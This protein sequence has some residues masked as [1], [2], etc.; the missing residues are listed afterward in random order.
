MAFQR[1]GTRITR[2]VD[3]APA[4]GLASNTIVV[5]TATGVAKSG[6]KAVPFFGVTQGASDAKGYADIQTDNVVQILAG[7]TIAAGASVASDANG[8]AVSVTPAGTGS[9]T[10]VVGTAI[11]AAVSGGLVDVLLN[12]QLTLS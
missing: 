7:G 4:T 9:L 2:P 11:T 10:Q 12:P 5:A 6:A 8:L 3:G 1:V